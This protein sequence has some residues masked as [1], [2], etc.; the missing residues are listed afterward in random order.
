MTINELFAHAERSLAPVLAKSGGILY[1]SVN[2]L[3]QGDIYVLGLNPGGE[4]GPSIYEHLVALP[5]KVDNSYIDESWEN[6]AG[7]YPP[8][9]APL[10]RRLKWLVES[11]GYDLRQICASNLIF[12]RSPDASGINYPMDADLCWPVHEQIINVVRP[13]LILSFGNSSV[14]PYEFL[15]QRFTGDEEWMPS[16]HGTWMCKG[17]MAAAQGHKFYV[18]GLPHLSRY[19]PI[20]KAN[21]V[22]WL[23][24]KMNALRS[25]SD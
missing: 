11:L 1:S 5:G 16:G 22:D 23:R 21:V 9:G 10:Q 2:T 25:S 3:T 19:S 7:C 6:R 14:S 12:M 24:G 4:S 15:R 17:F 13:K 20:N 8:G 18:A